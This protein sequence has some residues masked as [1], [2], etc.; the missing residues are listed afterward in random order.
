MS[1][2]CFEFQKE[3]SVVF[4]GATGLARPEQYPLLLQVL[5]PSQSQLDVHLIS[6][7]TIANS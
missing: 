5:L 3:V 2:K 6:N 4:G 7:S 1:I